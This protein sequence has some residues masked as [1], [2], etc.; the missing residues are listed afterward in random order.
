MISDLKAASAAGAWEAIHA[1]EDWE[2]GLLQS[3]T[4]VEEESAKTM[5]AIRFVSREVKLA[6]RD[7]AER[8]RDGRET[9]VDKRRRT[10]DAAQRAATLVARLNK[11]TNGDGKRREP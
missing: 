4:C 5:E 2:R 10:D 6:Q 1:Y 3:A 7:Q 9:D 11:S 8:K